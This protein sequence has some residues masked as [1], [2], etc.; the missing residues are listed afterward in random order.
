[1]PNQTLE[2]T[3]LNIATNLRVEMVETFEDNK[4]YGTCLECSKALVDKL[5]QAGIKSEIVIG[6]IAVDEPL[7]TD[8]WEEIFDPLHYWVSVGDYFVDITCSQFAEHMSDD[9]NIQYLEEVFVS[10]KD[11]AVLH[12]PKKV[13]RYD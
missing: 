8:D 2:Q 4:L 3:L 9:Y 13:Y 6:F 12:I 10:K 5:N 1:M 7:F 11:E